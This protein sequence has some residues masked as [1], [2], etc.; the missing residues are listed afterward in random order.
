MVRFY[1]DPGYSGFVL[2]DQ[3][4]GNSSFDPEI[5]WKD[6]IDKFYG[7]Y[8]TA[9]DEVEKIGG[10][11]KVFFG[12]EYAL[13]SRPTQLRYVLGN[14]FVILGLTKEWLL[15]NEEAF[16]MNP[17][18]TFDA[19]HAA[20]GFIIHAHPF[21]EAPWIRSIQLL[22]RKTDAVEVYNACTPD[23]H[24]ENAQWYADRYGLPCTGGSDIH[25]ATQKALAALETE[26]PCE[27]VADL[28]AAIRERKTKILR[29][30]ADELLANPLNAR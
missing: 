20:G 17:N 18:E 29:L 4:S 15:E 28:C 19:V 21:A 23:F 14:D 8:E 16:G 12:M 24:N 30:N 6:R 11:I 2:V 13:R 7:I 5:G 9:L 3:L 1:K 22:P 10:G 27:T 26:T 25:H